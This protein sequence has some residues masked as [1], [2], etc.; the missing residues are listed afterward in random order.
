VLLALGVRM[1]GEHVGRR[2]LAGVSAIAVAV[3]VLG[4]AAPKST[5]TFTTVGVAIVIAWLAV[6]LAGPY[7][8]RVLRAG[9]GLTG[10]IVAGLGWGAVGLATALVDQAIGD[11]RWI[12]A[13]LWGLGVAAASWGA[14]LAEMSALQVWPATRAIPVVF[15]LEM[16]L[17][18]AASPGLTVHGPGVYGGVPF[19]IA[20]AVAAA[21]AIVL[22]SS[23][24]VARTVEA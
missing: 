20:L 21:G 23:Q 7:V 1:L 5:G 4:W 14:L 15:A 17:P 11:R 10:S 16:V 8:L 18:A 12:V 22:G 3:G 13:V 19:A 2:E 24:A 9:T 6:S